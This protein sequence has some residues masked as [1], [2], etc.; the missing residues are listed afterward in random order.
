MWQGCLSTLLTLIQYSTE[1][2]SKINKQE[3]EIKGV[4][5]EKEDVQL[6]LFVDVMISYLTAPK[7]SIKNFLCLINTFSNVIRYKINI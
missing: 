1:I 7:D 4:R 6:Y 2:L 5:I 3:N